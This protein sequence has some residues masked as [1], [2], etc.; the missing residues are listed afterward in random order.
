MTDSNPTTLSP[1]PAKAVEVEIVLS[2]R[3]KDIPFIHRIQDYFGM[4][5]YLSVNYMSP[6][7]I[8]TDDPKYPVLLEGEEKGFYRIC[9]RPKRQ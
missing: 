8:G 1:S 3:I 7:N 5:R 4:S 2:W 6:I 9:R